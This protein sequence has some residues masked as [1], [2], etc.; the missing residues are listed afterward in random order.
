MNTVKVNKRGKRETTITTRKKKEV[1][2]K[3]LNN[4]SL[5]I[6]PHLAHPILFFWFLFCISDQGKWFK[7]VHEDIF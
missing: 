6:F 3:A 2:H 5:D 1:L 7:S 4:I